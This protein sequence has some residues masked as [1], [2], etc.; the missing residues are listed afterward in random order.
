MIRATFA[1]ASASWSP[2]AYE[3]VRQVLAAALDGV[4]GEVAQA[5]TAAEV[6]AD[7]DVVVSGPDLVDAAWGSAVRRS[8]S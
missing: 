6:P 4:A 8:S 5:V 2:A 1:A 7:A 3:G